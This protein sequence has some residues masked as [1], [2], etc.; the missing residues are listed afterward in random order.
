MGEF[1]LRR[2]NAYSST[3][4]S[5]LNSPKVLV[6]LSTKEHKKFIFYSKTTEQQH[7]TKAG[8]NSK[9]L[10]YLGTIRHYQTKIPQEPGVLRCL[11][12]FL[13]CRVYI[14]SLWKIAD[15]F[16]IL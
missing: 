4:P 16:V 14:A 10:Y 15:F 6:L 13:G 7:S 9:I 11:R 2:S 12:F 5:A 8:I 1:N 3:L